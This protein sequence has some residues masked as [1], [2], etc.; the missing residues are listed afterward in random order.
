MPKILAGGKKSFSCLV[1]EG[2]G[3]I[4]V[5]DSRWRMR[6]SSRHIGIRI[7]VAVPCEHGRTASAGKEEEHSRWQWTDDALE[8][9]YAEGV[10]RS[11][12]IRDDKAGGFDEGYAK[13]VETCH[14]FGK[15]E[16]GG[17]SGS[18]PKVLK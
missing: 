11:L 5:G 6:I 8:D 18:G 1:I 14:R 4:G 2:G 9:G 13:G 15:E 3:E 16:G 12:A 7:L 17:G 10:S